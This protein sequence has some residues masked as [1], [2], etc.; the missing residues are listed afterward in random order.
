VSVVTPGECRDRGIPLPAD[1]LVAQDIIDEQE[2]WLARRLG[3]LVGER[4]E[5]FPVGLGGTSAKLGLA[6]PTDSVDVVDGSATLDASRTRLVDHG[7]ALILADVQLT[8]WWAGPY[9]AVTYEPSDELEVRKAIFDLVGLAATPLEKHT[10]EQIGAYSYSGGGAQGI[11]AA[12]G[13]IVSSLLPKR[14]PLA[15]LTAVSRRVHADDPVINRA[16]PWT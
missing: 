1:D 10:S 5:T 14:D 2:A 15:V 7:S 13:V 3:L 6:R 4:T 8:P 11:A 16:E 9:V 12:R